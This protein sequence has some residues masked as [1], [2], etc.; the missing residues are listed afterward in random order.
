DLNSFHEEQL[1]ITEDPATWPEIINWQIRDY[2][3]QKGPPKIILEGFPSQENKTHFSKVPCGRKLSNGEIIYRP[4]I[5]YSELINKIFCF[6]C[7]L[8]GNDTTS[9]LTTTGFDNWPNVHNRLAEHEKL[10]GHLAA[11]LNCSEL[12]KRFSV[13]DTIDKVQQKL[14][15][16]E[17]MRLRQVFERFVSVVQFLAEGNL[18]FRGSVKG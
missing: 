16:Q 13:K 10:K 6:Y 18:T 15:N 1:N 3:V 11:M 8:F 12:Q 14:F 7:R 9:A 17:K 4:W 2:L 5:I